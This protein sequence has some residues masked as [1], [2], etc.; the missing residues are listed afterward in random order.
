MVTF[1]LENISA[2]DYSSVLTYFK[3]KVGMLYNAYGY[4][5]IFVEKV[6]HMVNENKDV[7]GFEVWACDILKQLREEKEKQERESKGQSQEILYLRAQ[8]DLYKQQIHDV[9][10][11][12]GN[13]DNNDPLLTW[14]TAPMVVRIEKEL[15]TCHNHPETAQVFSMLITN[16]YIPRTTILNEEFLNACL[17]HLTSYNYPV[18][19]LKLKEGVRKILSQS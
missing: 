3:N 17:P 8:N 5:A 6:M 9:F 19:A 4:Q 2:E 14:L 13:V 12:H 16:G 7:P 15:K 10:D 18:T 11:V 1:E